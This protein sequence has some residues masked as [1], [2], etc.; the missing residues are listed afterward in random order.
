VTRGRKATGRHPVRGD[1][2]N[3]PGLSHEGMGS[4]RTPGDEVR[5]IGRSSDLRAL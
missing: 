3:L 4:Q 1:S 2:E 5:T